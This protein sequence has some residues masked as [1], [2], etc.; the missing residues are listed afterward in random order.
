MVPF[1]VT[2]DPFRKFVPLTVRVNAA[3]PASAE[4]GT[5]LVRVGPATARFTEFETKGP[6]FVTV[7]ARLPGAAMAAAGTVAENWFT[8]TNALA[9]VVPLIWTVLAVKNPVPLMAMT[10]PDGLAATCAGFKLE[11]VGVGY[12]TGNWTTFDIGPP[13]GCTMSTES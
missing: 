10:I 9:T 5:R 3:L 11:I 1:H 6:G 4:D 2:R 8:L 13:F 7:T 12:K